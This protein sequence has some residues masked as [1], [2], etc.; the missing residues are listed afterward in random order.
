MMSLSLVLLG[1]GV[2]MQEAPIQEEVFR[3]QV[4]VKTV[5]LD[6]FV[7]REDRLV[8][9][10]RAEDF[11]VLDNGVPQQVKLLDHSAL[12]LATML[13]LDV[14]GSV[15]GDKLEQLRAAAHAFVAGLDPDDEVGLLTFTRRMELRMTPSSNFAA[16]HRVLLEPAEQGNTSLHDALYTGLKLVEA[17]GGRPLVVLFTDGLDNMSWLDESEVLDVLKESD[18]VVYAVAVEPGIEVSVQRGGRSIRGKVVV[19]AE[20]YLTSVTRLTGGRVFHIDPG[21]NFSEI[22]LRVLSEMASR[23]LLSYEPKGVQLEGW[24]KLEVELRTEE[25]DGIRTRPGYLVRTGR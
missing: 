23:Y 19:E 25:A 21:A 1:L 5:Y 8:K 13:L 17:R 4:D 6:V 15:E 7:T 22:F 2:L 18:V 16:L 3:F 11:V 10:L 9:G 24:H 12:P 20:E 14:S